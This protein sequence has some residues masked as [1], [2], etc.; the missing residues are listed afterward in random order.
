MAKKK[1]SKG[2]QCAA[3][4]YRICNGDMQ[5]M[6][7]T[8]RGTGRWI[9][10]KGWRKKKHSPAEM[11]ALEAFEEG[12]VVG[13]VTPKPIGMYQYNKVLNSGAIKPLVV[14]VF[15]LCVRFECMDWPERHQRKRI[16][17]APEEA[18][19]MVAEPELADLLRR[20]V[21]VERKARATFR[22]SL[23]AS[24]VPAKMHIVPVNA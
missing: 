17:V 18:A 4:P 21:K 3:I 24:P 22:D 7:L 14:D 8:S 12:G 19:L 16:W 1:I 10:P 20:F 6:L 13:D 2:R 9:V 11:A 5:V 15:G 23:V